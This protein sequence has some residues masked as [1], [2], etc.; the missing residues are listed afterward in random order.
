MKAIEKQRRFL[1][2][3]QQ[4]IQPNPK[5]V[6]RFDIAVRLFVNGER[7]YP[8]NDH[9]LKGAKLGLRAF[10]I[11]SD[12]RVVYKEDSLAYTFLDVGSHNQVY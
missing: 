11:G 2:H 8:L 3:Y 10:S 1:K 12:L 9:P 7:A 6:A 5:L 4:R